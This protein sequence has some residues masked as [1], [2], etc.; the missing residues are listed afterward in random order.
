M[1]LA[2]TYRDILV[3]GFDHRQRSSWL[4]LQGTFMVLRS[5]CQD[6]AVGSAPNGVEHGQRS[7]AFQDG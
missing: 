1:R 4:P 2:E 5:R 7:K 6:G 3:T